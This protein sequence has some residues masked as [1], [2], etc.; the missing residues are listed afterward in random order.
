MAILLVM[1]KSGRMA[2]PNIKIMKESCIEVAKTLP[3]RDMIGVIAFDHNARELLE[4]T[5][6]ERIDDIIQRIQRL[7]ANGGTR[8]QPALELANRM[9]QLD[10]RPQHCVVKHVIL[11]SDGDVP[12]G[13][14][15]AL[16]RNLVEKGATLSTVCVSGPRF[17]PVLM[18]Q[19]A[20]WGKG[21]FYFTDHF[22][23]VPQLLLNET[24]KVLAMNAHTP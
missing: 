4:F 17:D 8:L 9:I 20:T 22:E 14:Y 2:G 23:H 24:Q 5:E 16:V 13:D 19:I 3:R 7:E 21:R 6:A 11:V 12:E 1:D 10:P 18:S 15:E